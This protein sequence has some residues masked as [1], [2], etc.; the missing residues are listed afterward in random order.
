M[1]HLHKR[2]DKLPM[3]DAD[4]PDGLAQTVDL[5]DGPPPVVTHY[6]CDGA[7]RREITRQQ[8][9]QYAARGVPE[10]TE[11]HVNLLDSDIDQ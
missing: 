10:P 5:T 3:P 7:G 9:E 1:K 11:I 8:Y 6:A 4:A 2:L